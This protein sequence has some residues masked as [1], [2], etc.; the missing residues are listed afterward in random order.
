MSK[1]SLPHTHNL[2]FV[3]QLYSSYRRDAGTVSEE[4]RH[5]FA[6]MDNGDGASPIKT[7][8]TF[9]P[10]SLF[11]APAPAI[12]G[13][14]NLQERVDQV[15]RAYRLRGHMAAQIDPLG[16]PRPVP[17]ELDPAFY[18]LGEADLD[19]HFSC[20]TLTGASAP[21]SD[22]LRQLR[23]TYCR[24]IGVEHMHI[25]DVSIRRWLQARM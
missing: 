24:S 25:D 3:E 13:W 19:R 22:I 14:T 18:K 16:R 4:W 17:P 21:L 12:T 11:H 1:E 7:A 9:R 20:E 23:N 10:R 5:Y 6:E 8:P 15:V 2:E